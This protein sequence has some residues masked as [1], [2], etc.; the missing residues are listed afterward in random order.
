LLHSKEGISKFRWISGG[1]V[2]SGAIGQTH[3]RAGKAT[4]TEFAVTRRQLVLR[5]F[6]GIAL[7]KRPSLIP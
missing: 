7:M 4:A 3:K 1:F 6:G 5:Q 2:I